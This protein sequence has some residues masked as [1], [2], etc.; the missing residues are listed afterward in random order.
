MTSRFALA[1][2][3][4]V[5]L[6]RQ[7]PVSSRVLAEKICTN[8]A[9]VRQVAGPLCKAGLLETREGHAG[10]YAFTGDAGAVT[11]A[12]IARAVD[13]NF[14]TSSWRLG[15][16]DRDCLAACGMADALDSLYALL[17]DGCRRQLE[18][19]TLLDFELT[20]FPDQSKLI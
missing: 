5:Y 15:G 3:A 14:I 19:I 4:L 10:G 16:A 20:F 11:L 1:L 13:A 2:H 17:D 12:Q 7:G 6:H 18:Q 8:P 9:R